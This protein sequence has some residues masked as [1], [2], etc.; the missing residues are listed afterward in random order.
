M[1]GLIISIYLTIGWFYGIW[2]GNR[3]VFFLGILLL[4]VGVQFFSI[5]LL[6]ELLIKTSGKS[7][8]KIHSIY[9]RNQD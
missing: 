9:T 8:K 7:E 5:G 3:P 1:A 6:G 2:I 4:I